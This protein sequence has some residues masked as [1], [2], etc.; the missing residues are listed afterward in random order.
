MDIKYRQ[1][2]REDLPL[3][4]D[5]R[6]QEKVRK[7]CREYRLLNMVNQNNWFERV[8]TSKVDDMFLILMDEK[9]VGL[10]GLTHI[11]WKDRSAEISY[12]LGQSI[13]PT[14]DVALGIEIYDFFK[15]KGFGEY[16]LHR[17]WGEAFAFNEGAV[18]LALKCGFIQEGIMREAT[19][20]DGKYMDTII[21]SMLAHEYYRDAA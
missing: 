15:R 10:C 9:P 21:I 18:K 6:N 12:Y 14:E 13:S 16:N 3:L 19:F 20:W 4:R 7:Y 17:L 1:M 2:E 11:N 8:S 5:W